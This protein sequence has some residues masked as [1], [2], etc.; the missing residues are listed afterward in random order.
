MFPTSGRRLGQP[1]AGPVA[2]A[3]HVH[4]GH[5]TTSQLGH[6]GNRTYHGLIYWGDI[7]SLGF[8]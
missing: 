3:H 6:R 7:V 5:Y 2:A 1:L 4:G 8:L